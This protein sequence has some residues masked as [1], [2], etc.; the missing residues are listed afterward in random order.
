MGDFMMQLLQA[1][2]WSS[3]LCFFELGSF[4]RINGCCRKANS[5]NPE[6]ESS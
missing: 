3:I 1:V 5:E 4:K 6:A 2:I